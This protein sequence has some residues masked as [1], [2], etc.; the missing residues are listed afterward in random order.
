VTFSASSTCQ[1]FNL[2]DTEF[3]APEKSG[4]DSDGKEKSFLFSMDLERAFVPT[5][6]SEEKWFID[7]SYADFKEHHPEQCV[8]PPE[9]F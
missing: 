5:H 2:A 7:H 6:V 4:E 3:N 8:P 1:V 9:I